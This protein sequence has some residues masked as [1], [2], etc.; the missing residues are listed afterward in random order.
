[1]MSKSKRLT[2][3]KRKT[4]IPLATL[5]RYSPSKTFA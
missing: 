4:D 1:M 5:H 2:W 3:V